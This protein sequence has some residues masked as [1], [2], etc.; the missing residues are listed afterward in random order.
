MLVLM[1]YRYPGN[2]AKAAIELY[3]V[4]GKKLTA[5]AMEAG[6][7]VSSI[8]ALLVEGDNRPGLAHQIAQAVAE[9]GV[10]LSFVMAHVVGRRYA[11]TIGFETETDAKKASTL[12]KKA[13]AGRKK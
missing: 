2:E 9:A 12:I 1:A 5:S 7:S 11:A 8:P 4:S 6:L 3:P 10:N 13:T